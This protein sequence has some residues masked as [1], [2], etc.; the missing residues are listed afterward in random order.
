MRTVRARADDEARLLF[1]ERMVDKV[2]V[3]LLR[4]YHSDRWR[5]YEVVMDKVQ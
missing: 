3:G 1:K 5:L 2:V 4:F